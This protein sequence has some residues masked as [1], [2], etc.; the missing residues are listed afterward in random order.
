MVA[1]DGDGVAE[2]ADLLGLP[3]DDLRAAIGGPWN[4]GYRMPEEHLG[5]LGVVFTG[6]VDP[7]VP[8]RPLAVIQVDTVDG[9]LTVGYAVGF[10]LVTGDMRWSPAEPRTVMPF[11]VD[12]VLA[13]VD[14]PT[15][16]LSAFDVG[17]PEQTLLAC[18]R[19]AVVR[20]TDAA[21]LRGTTW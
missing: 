11:G 21:I 4:P 19:D 20:V 15:H 16:P 9:L 1:P 2:L 3:D 6:L 10:P 7:R 17:D 8:D 5:T 18:L 14:D 12:D 13:C